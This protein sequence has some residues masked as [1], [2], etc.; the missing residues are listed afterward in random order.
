MGLE[1]FEPKK[2]AK[3]SRVL[4]I[5]IHGMCEIAPDCVAML[6]AGDYDEKAKTLH[7]WCLAG[8][9]STI[10]DFDLYGDNG[11]REK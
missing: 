4:R 8:H 3:S 2:T 6:D 1:N 10:E 7:F 5:D 11:G 9:E